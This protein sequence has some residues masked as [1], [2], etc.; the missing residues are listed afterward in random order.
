MKAT[1]SMNA[2]RSVAARVAASYLQISANNSGADQYLKNNSKFANIYVTPL[3]FQQY[4]PSKESRIP[5]A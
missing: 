2:K 5:L 4:S 3:P 1:R